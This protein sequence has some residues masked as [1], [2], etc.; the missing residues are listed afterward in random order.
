MRAPNH[1]PTI[2][3]YYSQITLIDDWV[4]QVVAA[5]D[6]KGIRE[7]TLIIFTADHGLSLG[8]HGFW[9]HGGST[10]PSNLHQAAHSIPLIVNH[11]GQ[12]DVGQRSDLMTSN[13]DLFATLVDYLD[14]KNEADPDIKNP[15]RSLSGVLKGEAMADWGEDVVYSEQEETHSS[16]QW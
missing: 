1:L 12:I 10:F 2:R 6:A 15:S 14:L 11:P 3:N 9:G 5:L 13:L 4:G 16:L 7:N 8:H